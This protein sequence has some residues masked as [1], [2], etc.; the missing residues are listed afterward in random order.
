[1]SV[2]GMQQGPSVTHV[3]E[4]EYVL[5]LW[6]VGVQTLSLDILVF[7]TYFF[8]KDTATTEIYTYEVVG[9]VRCV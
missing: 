8:F 9:S 6:Y 7:C 1:M 4:T 5:A 2:D 3:V